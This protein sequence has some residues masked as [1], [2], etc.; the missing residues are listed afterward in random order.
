MRY[1]KRNTMNLISVILSVF[2]VMAV[3]VMVPGAYDTPAGSYS[4]ILGAFFIL[5]PLIN[6]LFQNLVIRQVYDPSKYF[7]S[8]DFNESVGY[9][10]LVCGSAIVLLFFLPSTDLRPL[11]LTNAALIV[12]L[13]V[14]VAAVTIFISQKFTKVDFLNDTILVK[15]INFFK[16][17]GLSQKTTTGLGVYTYDEFGSFTLKDEKL[18]LKLN[19]GR[20]QVS[21]KLP[22]EK[23]EQISK[24][25]V[26]KGL[27][28]ERK[29]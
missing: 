28:L 17:S 11:G 20:G 5:M 4:V 10:W 8:L 25:L 21:V 3:M 12:G 9:E 2:I 14:A 1:Y 19:D 22:K 15:G 18:V 7:F 29:G 13:W 6:A 23:S 26:A 24:Y 27:V 16:S